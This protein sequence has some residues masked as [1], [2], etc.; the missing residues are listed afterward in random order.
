[1]RHNGWCSRVAH[2]YR[3]LFWILCWCLFAVRRTGKFSELNDWKIQQLSWLLVCQ[4]IL[5]DVVN[6]RKFWS[7]LLSN[8]FSQT[9]E[10]QTGSLQEVSITLNLCQNWY[11]PIYPRVSYKNKLHLHSFS[12]FSGG[13]RWDRIPSRHPLDDYQIT[14]E[15]QVVSVMSWEWFCFVTKA[16]RSPSK[17]KA[18][19]WLFDLGSIFA[20]CVSLWLFNDSPPQ[21]SQITEQKK[22]RSVAQ[23]FYNKI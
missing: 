6:Q 17:R 5:Q 3:G 13:R 16:V 20:T 12:G 10:P 18:W 2:G 1:M 23:R 14:G 8:T 4:D 15:T 9:A 11:E 22:T 19:S 7:N 21:K